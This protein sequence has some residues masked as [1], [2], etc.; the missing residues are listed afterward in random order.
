MLQTINGFQ[1]LRRIGESN[2]AEIFHVLRLVGRGRGTEGAAKVLRDEYADDRVERG[3]LENEHRICS[4]FEHPNVIRTY[5]LQLSAKRPFLLM[6][7]VAGYNLRHHLERGRPNLADAI[8]WLAQAAD[9]LGYCHEMGYIH[10]DVKPQNI[11]VGTD[12][13]PVVIDFALA[14]RLDGSFT[15]YLVRRMT[16]RRR[17]GTWSYMS[18]EQIR[19]QRLTALTDVYTLGVTLFEVTTGHMPYAAETSQ[20][21]M[22]QHLWGKIPSVRSLR[23]DLPIELDEL[24]KAMMAKDPLDRPRGMGYV[25]G[26]LR[27]LVS[28]CRKIA[29]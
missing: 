7:Y 23:P 17:P 3:Y 21:L 11:V 26:K 1:V 10:R 12:G 5:E 22:E 8:D 2:T 14:T 25:S 19:N 24:I 6:A 20:S 29:G 9:G 16:E 13:V 15:K 27:G 4:Q 28:A 18:P